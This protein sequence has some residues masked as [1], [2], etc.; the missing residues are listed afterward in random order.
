M[1]MPPCRWPDLLGLGVELGA[2]VWHFRCL[3]LL[4]AQTR[5]SLQTPS[6]V[7]FSDIAREG[8]HL[9]SVCDLG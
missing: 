6:N 3:L 9:P 1:T 8:S 2:G 5:R 7:L 4:G